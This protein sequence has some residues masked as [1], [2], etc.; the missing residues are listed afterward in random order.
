MKRFTILSALAGLGALAAY[1]GTAADKFSAMDTD[2]N[3]AVT[4]AEFVSW[5]VVEGDHSADEASAKFA[6]LAGE[7]DTL[8]LAELESAMKAGEA[9]AQAEEDAGRY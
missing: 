5:A 9:D 2:G 3:D 6:K 4:E 8:T 1:A 7:D